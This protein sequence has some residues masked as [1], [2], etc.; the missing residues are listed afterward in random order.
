MCEMCEEAYGNATSPLRGFVLIERERQHQY[1]ARV[2]RNGHYMSLTSPEVR[3]CLGR[4][5]DVEF[6]GNGKRLALKI[7]DA[8]SLNSYRLS[9]TSGKGNVLTVNVKSLSKQGLV[10]AGQILDAWM[11]DCQT[12]IYLEP[13]Q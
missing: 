13:R 2:H 8:P 4:T 12:V 5:N 6:Y 11:S 9:A 7:L 1:G 3:A 10:K